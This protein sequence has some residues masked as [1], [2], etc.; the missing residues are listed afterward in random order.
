MTSFIKCTLVL[1]NPDAFKAVVLACPG[2]VNVSPYASDAEVEEY[3]RR[4]GADPGKVEMI[5]DMGWTF[6]PD[7]K[8]W[9]SDAPMG[10]AQKRLNAQ[11]PA[12]HVSC[13][14][15]DEM[16]LFESAKAFADLA[17]TRGVK[18]TWEELNG[19]HCVMDTEGMARFLVEPTR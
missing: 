7:D 19:G 17:K 6:Y 4:T 5:V 10:L 8:S 14:N 16:G 9:E 12:M 11:F 3:I 2:V 13:G 15:H 18:T 1:K